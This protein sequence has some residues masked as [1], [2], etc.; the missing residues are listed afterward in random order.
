MMRTLRLTWLIP[1]CLLAAAVCTP[2][3]ASA[4]PRYYLQMESF[5]EFKPIATTTAAT[6]A[7]NAVLNFGY[8]ENNDN[9]H[10]HFEGLEK[11]YT[12]GTAGITEVKAS[13]PGASNLLCVVKPYV[14]GFSEESQWP[15]ELS[16]DE[17]SGY[18]NIFHSP[19]T[20]QGF[21]FEVKECSLSGL[22]AFGT[23]ST[24]KSEAYNGV[25]LEY[26]FPE[27]QLAGNS[28]QGLLG[29]K[30]PK[31]VWGTLRVSPVV[32]REVHVGP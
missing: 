2:A 6:Y 16:G 8:W 27:S 3:D 25:N 17:A 32:G 23:N 1:L 11:L 22:Y 12:N 31:K 5:E 14:F 30:G 13:T 9:I 18:F 28:Y 15:S 24:V 4:A 26:V 29:I 20:N 19:Y 21:V 10:C 7:S